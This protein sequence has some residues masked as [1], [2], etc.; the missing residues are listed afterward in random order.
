M[1]Q[2][3]EISFLQT[4]GIILVVFGHSFFRIPPDNIMIRWIYAFH[5]P[6]F[7]F[8]SGYLL[9]YTHPDISDINIKRYFTHKAKRL[10]LP[11]I[12]I[13]SLVFVPKALMSKYAVRPITL[14]WHSYIDQ[15]L[16]P[17]HNVLGAYWFMPTL[18]LIFAF[19]IIATKLLGKNVTGSISILIAFILINVFIPFTKDSLLNISGVVY[20]MVY[21]I[22]GYDYRDSRLEEKIRKANGWYIFIITLSISILFLIMPYF[23]FYDILAAVNGIMLSIAL[24]KIYEKYQCHFLDHLYGATYNIY[25][26]SGIFQILSLQMLLHFVHLSPIVYIPLAF[27]F[28]IYGPLILSKLRIFHQ[29]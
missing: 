5:M 13:S 4:F 21:F 23:R 8:I 14:D 3:R 29:A 28:G 22:I 2:L 20:Y 17:Y 11:Y 15:L 24:S 12:V 26:F 19:F 1:R 16:I 10:I 9:K 25:L 7:F 27:I 18:F 6:L